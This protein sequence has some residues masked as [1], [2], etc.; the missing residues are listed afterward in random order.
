VM[1]NPVYQVEILNRV[2]S[3]YRNEGHFESAANAA[4]HAKQLAK[5]SRS[6]CRFRVI[7]RNLAT[8]GD[9]VTGWIDGE[10]R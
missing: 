3:S 2:L 5:R 8:G 10:K 4:D 1:D 6:F 9:P 7:K